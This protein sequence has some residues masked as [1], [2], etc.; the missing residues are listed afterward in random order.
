MNRTEA[1]YIV[2]QNVPENPVTCEVGFFRGEFSKIINEVLE[3][4]THYVIDTFDDK[5]MVSGDKD[6]N[7]VVV[8]DMTKM[9][10]YSR[11]LGYETIKGTTNDLWRINE[12]FDF[13]Y[14]DADHSYEWVSRDLNNVLTKTK[15][16]TVIGG[17]DYSIDKFPGCY[18][19]V[20]DFC[21]EYDLSILLLT[22]DGCPS[23]FIRVP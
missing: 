1:L 5:N 2:K 4:K 18:H 9:E 21:K 6:G 17:H 16:G 15:S 7:N 11:S 19:A 10:E 20:N 13:I 22:D 8:Q 14:I 3:P 23:Y 12:Q